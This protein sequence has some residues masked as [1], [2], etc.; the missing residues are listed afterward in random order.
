MA[1]APVWL[2][3][4]FTYLAAAVIAVPIARALGLGAIIG[5]LAAGIAIGPWGLA[6]VSN[7]QDIL[8][9]AEFGVVLMLFLVGLELQPS[10][11]WSLRR[12]ILGLGMAQMAGCA[13]LLWGCAWA[14]GLPW[15][16]ALVGA[17]GLAL[18]ST[19]IALQVLN[20]RNLLRTDSGQKAFSILL[21]QDVA[22]IPILAL[23][24]LL[25][26]AARAE[27]LQPHAPLDLLPEALKI[28]AVVAAIVFGGRWVLRPLLRWI[29]KSK[30]PEI[31]T[32][33]SLFLVVGIA[34]LMLTVG[35]SMALGAFLAGVLLADSEYRRELETDIE[36]FKGLLLGLFF[37]AVGMSIDFGVIAHHP[38]AMLGLLLGFLAIKAAVIWLL[39]RVTAMAYQE[40]PLFTLLLAQ[41]GEF[42]F[43][44]FQS[45]AT[46][47]AIAPDHASLLIGAVALSMLMGPLLLVWLDRVLLQRHA[48]LQ[49]APQAQ[50]ISEPQSAPVIIAGFGRYG[51]IVARMMLAQGVPATVLDHS[52]EMLEVA[53][54]F[55]YRVFYGDA[56]RV[57]LLRMAGA[58]QARILVVAVDAPEQSLKI[59]QLAKKHFPHLHIVAR[60]RDVTHWHALRD[61]GVQHVERELFE[62]S[63]R[64]ARTVLEL[65][66]LSQADAD[67]LAERFR[68]HNIALSE[69]MYEHHNDR[70]AMIAVARQGRQ[71]LVEQLAKE[72]QE[73]MAAAEAGSGLT[74]DKPQPGKSS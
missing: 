7:V 3:Y 70:E 29:A 4:G 21:F 72:R 24:P 18:S 27:A 44:V 52:V 23:L 26:V 32:A 31:F 9:F 48:T 1:Q 61:L 39:A 14:L 46:F 50:E 55:G 60:A 20:E 33:A 2:T 64:T 73:R 59:V 11:L 8:H 51:Q 63:L 41:G 53:H 30:T 62:S 35:L 42:A 36:P 58:Q 22:A 34:M 40:R 74:P 5:Y 45:G 12:P 38:F 13:L 16:V 56:T 10:R 57:N 71:Q 17:L 67:A 68:A 19:A 15:R 6:L 66:G 25:G 37:I 47:G 43:V 54:T 65:T 69:R 49:S 28:I